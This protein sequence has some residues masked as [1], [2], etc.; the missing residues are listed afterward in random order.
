MS[1]PKF[2]FIW[3]NI[4]TCWDQT[5]LKIDANDLEDAR[6]IV[7]T[8]YESHI[9]LEGLHT[10]NEPDKVVVDHILNNEPSEVKPYSQVT[11]VSHISG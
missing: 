6:E 4:G 11:R 5:S 7:K 3:H 10:K 2:S 9:Y 1:L 8:K